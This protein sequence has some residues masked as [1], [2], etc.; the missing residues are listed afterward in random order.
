MPYK[1]VHPF[2][3]YCLIALLFGCQNPTTNNPNNI[4]ELNK[5]QFATGFIFDEESEKQIPVEA[6]LIRSIYKNNSPAESVK[7]WAPVPQNQNPYGTCVS[8]STAFAARTILYARDSRLNDQASIT[9]IAFSPYFV[10]GLINETDCNGADIYPAL[11]VLKDIGVTQ[12][13]DY[14]NCIRSYSKETYNKAAPYRI[15]DFVRLYDRYGE[16]LFVN[17]IDKVKNAIQNHFPVVIGMA[18]PLS[19]QLTPS[20][21]WQPL[22]NEFPPFSF[23]SGTNL[24]AMCIVS[25]DDNKYGGAFEIMNSWGT[26]W[27][28]KGFVWVKYSDFDKWSFAAYKLITN[29][30]PPQPTPTPKPQE[31]KLAGSFNILLSDNQG[32]M[33]TTLNSS[34]QYP[35]YQTSK[36][37]SSGTQFKLQINNQQPAY[38]YAFSIDQSNHSVVCFPYNSNISPILNNLINTVEI[39]YAQKYFTLD[40]QTGTDYFCLLYSNKSLNI[41]DIAR[42]VANNPSGSLPQ[43]LNAVLGNDLFKPANINYQ[44]DRIAFRAASPDNKSVVPLIIAVK[45]Q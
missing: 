23:S 25:Y 6:D 45:H 13:K 42:Q 44:T 38:V 18:V 10:H 28:N 34:D 12:F 21:L 30:K 2:L 7:Q 32:N 31:L 11:N 19:F 35:I 15:N 22:P 16:D 26:Q 20:D 33:P 3:I 8:F 29:I 17:K 14:P 9:R 27:A 5:D 1:F 4:G 43:R 37:Y 36:A 39:P 41:E 24:H 40:N